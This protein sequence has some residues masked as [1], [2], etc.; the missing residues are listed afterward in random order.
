MLT[1]NEVSRVDL[2]F[3]GSVPG[4]KNLG[5]CVK[6]HF[7]VFVFLNLEGR[8]DSKATRKEANGQEGQWLSAK[9]TCLDSG[10]K[11]A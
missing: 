8:V 6:F 5:H 10:V 1:G 9:K 4:G 3:S 11:Q 7:G 2:V